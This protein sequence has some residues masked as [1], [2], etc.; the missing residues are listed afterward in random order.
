MRG[1]LD[2]EADLDIRAGSDSIHV[3]S[4]GRGVQVAASSLAF[5][6]ELP[7]GLGGLSGLRQLSAGLQ[8]ADQSITLT[9]RGAPIVDLDPARRS[10]WLGWLLRVPGLRVHF[11]NWLR[12]RS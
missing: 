2:I 7:P 4:Q 9:A 3:K 6:R 8:M 1:P 10:R 11:F 5:L 12:N